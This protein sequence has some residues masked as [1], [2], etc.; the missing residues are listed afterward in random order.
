MWK[1]S[2]IFPQDIPNETS[3]AYTVEVPLIHS[4]H[5]PYYYYYYSLNINNIIK[6]RKVDKYEN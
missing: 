4:L 2:T 5:S 3:Y 6:E 1:N